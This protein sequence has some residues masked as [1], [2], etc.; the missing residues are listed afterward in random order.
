MAGSRELLGAGGTGMAGFQGKG[1][2]EVER[3]E[4]TVCV[5]GHSP[6]YFWADLAYVNLATGCFWCW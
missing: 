2:I 5:T 4:I 1:R 6:L 3:G